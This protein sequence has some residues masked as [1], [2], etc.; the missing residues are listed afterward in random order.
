MHTSP[1]DVKDIFILLL[2]RYLRQTT[3]S[4]HLSSV[5]TP[6]SSRGS[7]NTRGVISLY[8][9]VLKMEVIAETDRNAAANFDHRGH[10]RRGKW[11]RI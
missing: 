3:L 4:H 6:Q 9:I 8:C 11:H 2:R 1:K 5:L 10:H 7:R